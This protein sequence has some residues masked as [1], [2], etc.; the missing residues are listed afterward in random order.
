MPY[1]WLA[2]YPGSEIRHGRHVGQHL[3][4]RRGGHRQ[5]AQLAGPDIIGGAGRGGEQDLHLA[6]EQ[7]G[8]GGTLAPIGHV[9]QVDAGHHVEQ[10]AR[11]VRRAAVAGRRHV[12]LAGIGFGI[13]DEFRNRLGRNRRIDQN[14]LRH[15]DDACDRRDVADEVEIEL[16]V[17][18]RVDGIRNG[19]EQQR[20]AVGGAFTTASVPILPPAPGRLSVMKFC[21]SRC[22]QPL[23]DQARRDVDAA[24]GRETG[25]DV[26]RPRR[27]G[28]CGR[29]ARGGRERGS[30]CR[31]MQQSPT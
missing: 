6:A 17:E 11:H 28:L 23:T 4:A 25:D 31:Q 24:A 5:R 22:G 10:L 13:A 3:R 14:D 2:S 26:H 16:L 7:I 30:S 19:G 21:P 27:I 20:V 8:E 12:D 18:R 29:E 15:P 1:H 9:H